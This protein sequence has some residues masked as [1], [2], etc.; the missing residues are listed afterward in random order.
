MPGLQESTVLSLD[1][2]RQSQSGNYSCV[3]EN[4]SGS[5]SLQ[6]QVLVTGQ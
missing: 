6:V 4:L 3:A 1:S 2:P 5:S